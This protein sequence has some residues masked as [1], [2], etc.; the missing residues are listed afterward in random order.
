MGK[1]SVTNQ[2]DG[3]SNGGDGP[4]VV[5]GDPIHDVSG[6]L[7]DYDEG[8][9]VANLS[10]TTE[11]ILPAVT[12]M[13]DA[14]GNY[15]LQDVPAASAFFVT[16]AGV[17]G[18]YRRTINP[19]VTVLDADVAADLMVVTEAYANRLYNSTGEEPAPN[20]SLVIADLRKPDGSALIGVPAAAISLQ[21][22]AGDPV[23][24]GPFFIGPIGNEIAIGQTET[25]ADLTGRARIVY[26]DVPTGMNTLTIAAAAPEPMPG[27][28]AGPLD[29]G[30]LIDAPL[31]DAPLIDAPL[32]DALPGVDGGAGG[33]AMAAATATVVTSDGGA[34]LV[35]VGSV[36]GG[37]GG[38]GTGGGDGTGGGSVPLNP[39]FGTHVY[40]IL[41]SVANGGAGCGG[42][43]KPG[44][45]AGGVII[46]TDGPEAVHARITNGDRI[47]N[48][49][50]PAASLLLS[51]PLYEQPPNHPNAIFLTT[52]DVRYRTILSW[53]AGGA[54]L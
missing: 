26:F 22:G 40:P 27:A 5:E 42:C 19:T 34:T 47:V 28:D 51:K 9:A 33:G 37:G 43:H 4:A 3:G 8:G 17:G 38:M 11:G 35:T 30:L 53:I 44:G 52:Q 20:T 2:F 32:I 15:M 49:A 13:S 46:Y 31:I 16:V 48:L 7:R 24:V 29:A 41:Q 54:P 12:T 18:G 23:G 21:N 1:L 36:G 6:T 39:T 50:D 25:T 45:V 10:I 14:E